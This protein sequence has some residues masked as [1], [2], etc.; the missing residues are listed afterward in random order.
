MTAAPDMPDTPDRPGLPSDLRLT[1]PRP[2]T[3]PDFPW[4]TLK[5]VRA[6]AAPV[7]EWLDG[8]GNGR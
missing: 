4:D 3:L 5:P 7:S 8:P 1:L 6:P 2:L